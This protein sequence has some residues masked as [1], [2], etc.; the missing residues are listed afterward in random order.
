MFIQHLPP[1]FLSKDLKT[2]HILVY[3]LHLNMVKCLVTC[4]HRMCAVQM[5]NKKKIPKS[6]KV[7]NF[8]GLCPHAQTIAIHMDT[9]RSYFPQYFESDGEMSQENHPDE[10][11]AQDSELLDHNIEGN[12]D[13]ET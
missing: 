9:V 12:F 3:M 8:K 2:I 11:N 6:A 4:T 13:V 1:N 5:H 10:E 7:E